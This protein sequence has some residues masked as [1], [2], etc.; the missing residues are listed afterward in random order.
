MSDGTNF[1][2]DGKTVLNDGS[3][4]MSYATARNCQLQ[5]QWKISTE[6][7]SRRGDP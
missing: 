2:S 3:S 7:P 5:R 1:I 4:I 6:E